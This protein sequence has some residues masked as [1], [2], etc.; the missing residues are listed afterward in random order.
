MARA[1]LERLLRPRHAVVIGGGNWGR[2]V[3]QQC[4]TLG[5]EGPLYVVHPHAEEIE[6]LVPYRRVEDLPEAP[7]ACFVAV[8]RNATIDV[9]E[10]LSRMGAGGA[11]CFAAGFKETSDED[12]SGGDLQEALIQAA[13]NMPIIGPNCYGFVNYLDQFCLWPDQHGAQPV[14][15]G[16]GLICQSSNI[17]INL[18]M[19]Q[20]GLP[21]AYA[22]TV[23]NQAQTS[24][25]DLAFE[26]LED[27]RVTALGLYIEGI[28]NLGDFAAM[29]RRAAHLGKPIVAM[30]AG[31]SEQAQKAALSHTASLTGSD[32]GASALFERLGI[33]RVDSLSV[34]IETLKILH[35][36]GPLRGGRV[37][38][39][40]CSG[41]EASLMA[42][43]VHH[44]YQHLSFPELTAHQIRN[45]R[46]ALGPMIAL[47]NPLDY[48][49]F[50]WGDVERMA[51]TFQAMMDGPV[52]IA[53]IIV[54]FPRVDRCDPSAWDC[55]LAAAQTAA[56]RS[57]TPLALMS[58]LVENM[59]EDRAKQIADMG[60]IPLCGIDEGLSA[61]QSAVMPQAL[62]DA[63]IWEPVPWA[64][65]NELVT[66]AEAKEALLK[67]GL[68]V[69]QNV[70]I[71]DQAMPLDLPFEYPV[72]LKTT[73]VAH[74]SEEGGV[75]VGIANYDE[76]C[77]AAMQMGQ[78]PFLIEEMIE[79]TVVEL[80]VGIICDPAH[81]FV[82]TLAAGGVMTEV[83]ADRVHLLCPAGAD[84]IDR[85]LS[86]LKIAPLLEGYRNKAGADRQVVV[87]AIMKVQE[88]VKHHVATIQEV[89]INPLIVTPHRAVVADAL[90]TKGKK[91][92][93]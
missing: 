64:I 88:F 5:F 4:R 48:N 53:T 79:E 18:T 69:P 15:S 60:L 49:T 8:N 72:V 65:E 21:I 29:A 76:L 40:S 59:P 47:A 42:D 46:A 55:I 11:I 10:S 81:G 77:H 86:R 32:A 73:G 83:L 20:R 70:I 3:I 54:D 50:I 41:G 30:K 80:L 28:E 67:F 93:S 74:K 82:L 37:A 17:L 75:R 61:I 66:E 26:V 85:A 13:G 84:E 7:D 68:D 19:Q 63:R 16:V 1:S 9:I 12:Q 31:R 43:C 78:P 45:L 52:D 89:E 87:D 23:G 51:T 33:A 58:S 38:S 92:D 34:M 24:L 6:G 44:A 36:A 71:T 90:I 91:H 39:L 57:S 14:H 25:S 35:F 62:E 27:P 2:Q 56:V 22:L